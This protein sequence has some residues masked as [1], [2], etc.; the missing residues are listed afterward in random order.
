MTNHHIRSSLWSS[1]KTEI[2]IIKSNSC[3][4]VGDGKRINLWNDAWCGTPLAQSLQIP[5]NVIT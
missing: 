5:Q 1:L 4:R 3:W 2:S